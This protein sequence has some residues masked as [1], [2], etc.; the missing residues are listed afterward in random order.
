[1]PERAKLPDLIRRARAA[2]ILASSTQLVDK[3]LRQNKLRAYRVGRN[4]LI[5]QN[6]LLAKLEAGELQ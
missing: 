2:E 5:D 1:M 6:E 3:L 4:V